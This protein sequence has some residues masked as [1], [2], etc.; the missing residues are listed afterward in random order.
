MNCCDHHNVNQLIE[1][2]N[3]CFKESYQTVLIQGGI[4][5]LYIPAGEEKY[6]RLIFAH[7]YFSSA[8]HE[9]A[10]W[11]LAGPERRQ[12]VDFAYW[13]QPD[14]RT[15]KQQKVFEQVEIKP[16]ALE[17]IFAKAAGHDFHFSADNL[18]AGMDVSVT[19]KQAVHEQLAHYLQTG[20]PPRAQRFREVLLDYYGVSV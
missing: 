3:R 9:I 6:H 14:G 15:A 11:C 20:L 18:D 13:Y 17:W 19:F 16:Q 4:E 7:D 8:L 2:F 12:Q 1:L 5:P 10:H